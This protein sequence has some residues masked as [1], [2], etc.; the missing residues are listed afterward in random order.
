[1]QA[2]F[3]DRVEGL[4]ARA[5]GL[6]DTADPADSLHQWLTELATF[7]ATTRGL[8][9]SLNLTAEVTLDSD[10]TCETMLMRAGGELLHLAQRSGKVRADLDIRELLTLV[11]AV[12]WVTEGNSEAEHAARRLLNLAL[13]GIHND[14]HI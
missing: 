13:D 8:A 12:A 11:N 10:G 3:H 6:L 9:Q 5:D 4:C 1:M 7:G 14:T 2:V